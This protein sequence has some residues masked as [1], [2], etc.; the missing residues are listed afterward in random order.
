MKLEMTGQMRMEQRMKLAPH[1]IQ[2]MEILQLPILALQERIEQELNDNPVL[3]LEEPSI[4]DDLELSEP[5][6]S[7]PDEEINEKDLVVATDN[8][9]ADDFERLDSLED[10]FKDFINQ[11]GP[12][13]ARHDAGER[14]RKLEALNNTA[15]PPQSLHD[16]LTDQWRMVEADELVKKAG[17]A[18]IDYIDDRG[19][20]SV[21]LEQL[22]NKDRDPF[23]VDHLAE[24]LRLVQQLDPPGVGARDLRECLLIQL[25]QSAEDMSFEYRL[26]ADH[27]DALLENRLPDIAKK[28]E[29]GIDRIKQ[30]VAHLSKLD[31]SPGLQVGRSENI[32]IT[33]D[34]IVDSPNGS[35]ELSVRLTEND[36][37][38]LRLNPYYTRMAQDTHVSES[39][40][41]FLTNNVRSAQWI[42]EAIE[43]RKNTLLKV[44]RAIVRHQ[45]DFFEKG[46]LYL[47]PL[48]MSK[49][50]DEVGVHLATVSRAVSGKYLQ[51]AWGILPLRKFFSGGTEDENGQAHSWE[52]I[53]VKLQQIID[54]EDKTNPLND[55]QIKEKLAEAGIP[56]LARRTIAKYRKL[57]NIPTAR[58]RKR[59]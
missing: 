18:I 15:A 10:D 7:A 48:P 30:A 31:T 32:A 58:F 25:A 27:M 54:E 21:R 45:Q 52:A 41:K 53:R 57:M 22:H 11:S 35:D 5:P 26:V 42:I 50:A 33:P 37:P 4:A 20:L 34:V 19:Y 44:A 14:D 23:T 13:H 38:S 59:Y 36:L 3:E 12:Y 16:Y 9:R 17:S 43:Q 51:C 8:D 28:M 24:A 47:R 46:S 39:A 55:D 56:N 40:R 1:M 2:S 6:E 49:I 29:C